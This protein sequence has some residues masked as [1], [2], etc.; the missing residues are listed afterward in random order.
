MDIHV[1]LLLRERPILTNLC[2]RKGL[3]SSVLDQLSKSI[4][5]NGPGSA[6]NEACEECHNLFEYIY[7]RPGFSYVEIVTSCLSSRLLHY[8]YKV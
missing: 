1:N 3:K 8:Q 6:I 4:F 2:L 7:S 5:P